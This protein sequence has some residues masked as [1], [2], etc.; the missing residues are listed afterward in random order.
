VFRSLLLCFHVQLRRHV[1][2]VPEHWKNILR[3]AAI[4]IAALVTSLFFEE[5]R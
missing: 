4:R 3:A 5:G 2:D 1:A